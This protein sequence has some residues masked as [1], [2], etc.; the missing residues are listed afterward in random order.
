MSILKSQ[1]PWKPHA[2][3]HLQLLKS[4]AR[5]PIPQPSLQL[6]DQVTVKRF[7]RVESLDAEHPGHKEW[8]EKYLARQQVEAVNSVC[9]LSNQPLLK[10]FS[11]LSDFDS[12]YSEG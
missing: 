6:H 4:K 1:A 8:R 10:G 3:F 12:Y 5:S 11:S 2:Q 7:L 9:M